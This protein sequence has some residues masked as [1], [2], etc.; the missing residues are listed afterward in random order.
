MSNNDLLLISSIFLNFTGSLSAAINYY[1]ALW[2]KPPKPHQDQMVTSPTL[3][4]WGAGD[5]YFD[6]DVLPGHNKFVKDF[7]LKKISG[8]S[9][10]VQQDEPFM[11]NKMMR[12]FLGCSE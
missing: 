6:Q 10:W 1:R 5:K 12:E 8:A 11:V 4:I 7:T 2:Q 9:H 3:L